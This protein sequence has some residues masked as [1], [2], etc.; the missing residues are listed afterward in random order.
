MDKCL[1]PQSSPLQNGFNSIALCKAL[2][3]GDILIF[4]K[5]GNSAMPGIYLHALGH[6]WLSLCACVGHSITGLLSPLGFHRAPLSHK[7]PLK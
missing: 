5:R 7:P 4:Q 6:E 2:S 3:D 1:I